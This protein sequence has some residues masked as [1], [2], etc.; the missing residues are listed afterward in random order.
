[1]LWQ[2]ATT[3]KYN[4]KVQAMSHSLRVSRALFEAAFSI[5][6]VFSRSA[7]QQVEHW[8]RLGKAM[9]KAGLTVDM[10]MQLFRDGA[11]E[12]EGAMRAHKRALQKRDIALLQS[13]RVRQ[14]DMHLFT[15][16]MAKK[17]KVLNGP[18]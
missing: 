13:G 8:A 14:E 10:A 2:N 15:S 17:A 18:Y 5:G 7:A 6:E 9:E 3:E 12:S 4:L 16:E 1:M 11:T